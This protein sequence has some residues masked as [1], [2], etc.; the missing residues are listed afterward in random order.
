MH[1]CAQLLNRVQLFVTFMNWSKPGSSV[2]GISQAIILQWVAIS[3]SRG[4]SWPR[5][6]IHIIHVSFIVGEFFTTEPPEQI[7]LI[8]WDISRVKQIWNNYQQ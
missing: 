3:S 4:S 2:H 5:D 8:F 6:G 7:L 1:V